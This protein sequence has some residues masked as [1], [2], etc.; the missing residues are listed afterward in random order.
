MSFSNE[1]DENQLSRSP[2]QCVYENPLT[3]EGISEQFTANLTEV[4]K[5]CL[6]KY[7]DGI[8]KPATNSA[9]NE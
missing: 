4:V 8:V 7:Q 1:E 2:K 9:I 6:A 3:M 5:D